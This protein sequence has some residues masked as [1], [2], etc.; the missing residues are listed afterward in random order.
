MLIA[1]FAGRPTIGEKGFVKKIYLIGFRGTGFRDERFKA[2]NALIRAGHV[3]FSFQDE[4]HV[5]WGFHPTPQAIEGI[6]GDDAAIAWLKQKNTL[7]GTLQ[8]DTAIFEHADDLQKQGARTEVWQLAI[9]VS[10]EE[11]AR[12]QRIALEWYNTQRVFP[13]A[14]PPDEPRDDRDNCAT[15]PRRLGLPMLDS[16]GQI[17]D[18]VTVLQEKGERW[19]AQGD[20][21][22]TDDHR[23]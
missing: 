21:D 5:I 13:Y 3:G 8:Q 4:R 14:F 9:E 20:K 18:Y 23:N 16:V 17:K 19:N 12:I 22:V 7:D 6:G 10:E 2:E 1:L 11:F 15:F